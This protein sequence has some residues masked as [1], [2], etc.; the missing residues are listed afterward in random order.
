MMCATALKKEHILTK[1]RRER[2]VEGLVAK[3]S[4]E[5]AYIRVSQDLI[6]Q[7]K[8]CPQ[9]TSLSISNEH[10]RTL[11]SLDRLEK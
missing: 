9:N 7:L 10:L 2:E 3:L 8:W 1:T 4:T 5:E 11:V 6:L